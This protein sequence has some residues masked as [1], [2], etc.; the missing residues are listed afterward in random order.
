MDLSNSVHRVCSILIYAMMV[1]A[2]SLIAKVVV[3]VDD[4]SVVDIAFHDGPWP[5][6]IDSNHRTFVAVWCCCNPSY[7]PIKYEGLCRYKRSK[8]KEDKER[9]CS[10]HCLEKNI[11]ARHNKDEQIEDLTMVDLNSE[12]MRS[13]INYDMR[14]NALRMSHRWTNKIFSACEHNKM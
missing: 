2:R 12:E 6:A 14:H 5:L 8:L 11:S 13:Y 7:V 10:C 1:K 3:D 4:D 9:H